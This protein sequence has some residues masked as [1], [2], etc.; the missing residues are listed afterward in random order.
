MPLFLRKD[1]N[2]ELVKTDPLSVTSISG[3]PW[4]A[5]IERNFSI[6]TAEVAADTDLTST[7]FERVSGTYVLRKG[8]HNLHEHEP[9]D[10]A[11]IPKVVVVLELVDVENV[12]TGYSFS[13]FL[14]YP[15][16][17]V[18]TRRNF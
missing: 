9:R 14:Q 8:Q 11:A 18:A 1:S 2:S 16:P 13:L 3:R 6:V 12:D 17:F 10:V 5:K 7:H 15:C 4:V